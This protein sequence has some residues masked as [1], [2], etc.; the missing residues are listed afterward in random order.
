MEYSKLQSR[1]VYQKRSMNQGESI[2]QNEIEILYR[3]IFSFLASSFFL[4]KAIVF[5][6]EEDADSKKLIE[7]ASFN[8][9]FKN[10]QFQI[11]NINRGAVG[12]CF[13]V[14]RTINITN[15]PMNYTQSNWSNYNSNPKQLLLLPLSVPNCKLGVLEVAFNNILKTSIIK[16][17]E[18]LC[19]VLARDIYKHRQGLNKGIVGDKGQAG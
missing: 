14:Q 6:L 4:D 16:E 5:L 18:K 3:P 10:E 7:V 12:G 15:L 1:S 2:N 17:I 8:K 11:L 19:S 9:S 13:Q